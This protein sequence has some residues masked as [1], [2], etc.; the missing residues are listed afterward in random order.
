MPEDPALICVAW[1]YQ[2][3][4]WAPTEQRWVINERCADEARITR[5]LEEHG[6]K[7]H[8]CRDYVDWSGKVSL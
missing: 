2:S 3:S 1:T 8:S 7:P 5:L 6:A 4:L